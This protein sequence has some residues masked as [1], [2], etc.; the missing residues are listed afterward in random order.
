MCPVFPGVGLL[1]DQPSRDTWG[2]QCP[3]EGAGPSSSDHFGQVV[4][5]VVVRLNDRACRIGLVPLVND[6]AVAP[7]PISQTLI[8]PPGPLVADLDGQPD[9]GGDARA[10]DLLR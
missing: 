8:Q 5:W 6:Q 2:T 10:G 7:V 1:D 3:D 9:Q 4:A